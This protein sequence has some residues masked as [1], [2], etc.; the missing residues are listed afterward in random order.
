MPIKLD[1]PTTSRENWSGLIAKALKINSLDEFEVKNVL[2]LEIPAF[3]HPEDKIQRYNPLKTYHKGWQLGICIDGNDNL[4]Q[5]NIQNALRNGAEALI[6]KHTKGN[7]NQLYNGVHPEMIYTD[8]ESDDDIEALHSFVNFSES[9]SKKLETLRGSISLSLEMLKANLD[10]VRK[11]PLFHL[12]TGILSSGKIPEALLDC[13]VQLNTAIKFCI[14]EEL[15]L[16]S[17]RASAI[18]GYYMPANIAKLRALRIIWSNLLQ[19]HKQTFTPLFIR[20][21]T[22]V[23]E[24]SNKESALIENTSS[25]INAAFGTA[26]MIYNSFQH[27]VNQSRLHLNIQH[28]MKMESKLDQVSDPLAGAYAIEQMTNTLAEN[29]WAKLFE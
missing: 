14:R 9:Q 7:W 24:N 20:A 22:V 25:C 11:L 6:L 17:I 27:D 8:I 21:T 3:N 10:M 16:S 12:F 2:G 5:S 23:S 4:A 13:A 19:A 1:F 15:P 28:I 29:C 26:D 18:V